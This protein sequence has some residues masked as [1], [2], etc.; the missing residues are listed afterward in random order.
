MESCDVLIVGGGPGGAACARELRGAGFDVVVM[1][2]REFPRT[3]VCAGWITK[4]VVESL[5][6]DLHDYARDRVL[7]PITG[8][9]VGAIGGK[10]LTTDYG[11]VISYGILRRQFDEYLL[12]RCGARLRLGQ[13]FK[14][15]VRVGQRWRVNDAIDAG[16]IIGAGGH[17]CPVARMLGAGAVSEVVVG[18][19]ELEFE[20]TAAQARECRVKPEVPEL[21]FRPDFKGYAWCFRKGNHLNI[22]LGLENARGLNEQSH[23][24]LDYYKSLGR[25]PRDTPDKFSGHAYIMY[26]HSQREKISDGVMLIGDAAGLAYPESGEG[27]LPAIESGLM[28]AKVASDAAGD[29]S[30]ARLEP[31]TQALLSRY[32]KPRPTYDI[33]AFAVPVVRMLLGVPWAVRL[34]M[35]W[36]FSQTKPALLAQSSFSEPQLPVVPAAAAS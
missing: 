14:K 35:T 15:A 25:I 16:L 1:D 18:A 30:R 5:N 21:F 7:Q 23:Q 28:A 34:L 31:Y 27:I 32:G 10:Q 11:D 8:F 2:R 29:Y 36:S 19:Q 17:F 9:R 20:M 33:P 4:G 22:G 26:G 13:A 6:I 12:S 24:F 3:K